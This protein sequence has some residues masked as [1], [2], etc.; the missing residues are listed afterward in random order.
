MVIDN[1]FEACNEKIYDVLI[2]LI[3]SRNGEAVFRYGRIAKCVV[4]TDV[5]V[6]ISNSAGDAAVCHIKGLK[7]FMRMQTE[8]T[9]FLDVTADLRIYSLRKAF[10]G[11]SVQFFGIIRAVRT[12]PACHIGA[13]GFIH[14]DGADTRHTLELIP[15]IVHG[16]ADLRAAFV[17]M[18]E[19]ISA[20]AVQT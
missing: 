15:E 13:C 12:V 7:E 3:E 16:F 6:V 19:L 4:F 1:L 18:L 8:V 5:A 9:A 20:D 17:V 11:K 14:A 2:Q 10:D